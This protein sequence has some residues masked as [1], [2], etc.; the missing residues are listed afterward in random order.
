[1]YSHLEKCGKIEVER[2]ERD[3]FKSSNCDKNVLVNKILRKKNNVF[4]I[5]IKKG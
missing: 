3:L 1:M 4:D 5:N 2:P